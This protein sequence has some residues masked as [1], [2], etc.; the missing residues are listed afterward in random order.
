MRMNIRMVFVLVA[1]AFA[2]AVAP[3]NSA[4]AQKLVAIGHSSP[5]GYAD[6]N[7]FAESQEWAYPGLIAQSVGAEYSTPSLVGTLTTHPVAVAL[8]LTAAPHLGTF[9]PSPYPGPP[10]YPTVGQVDSCEPH[11]NLAVPG[12]T[13]HGALFR[14]QFPLNPFSNVFDCGPSCDWDPLCTVTCQLGTLRFVDFMLFQHTLFNALPYSFPFG[15]SPSGDVV[16][17]ADLPFDAT[18][19]SQVEIAGLLEPDWI[20]VRLE[21]TM[22]GRPP[23][24]G[25]TFPQWTPKSSMPI[26]RR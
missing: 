9:E 5:A 11:T 4:D 17:C 18:P 14:K 20:L 12:E 24:L 8:G 26:T 10:P 22:L 23:A 16:P 19:R 3:T 25:S 21:R 13:V 15:G 2:M 6:G 1:F 7:I